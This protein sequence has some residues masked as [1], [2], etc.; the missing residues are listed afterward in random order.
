MSKIDLDTYVSGIQEI[1]NTYGNQVLNDCRLFTSL[2]ND[3][4]SLSTKGRDL[5]K[6]TLKPNVLNQI[7]SVNKC[8]FLKR[9]A[10][11]IKLESLVE[12]E[13]LINKDIVF[14]VVSVYAKVFSWKYVSNI[15]SSSILSNVS[16]NSNLNNSLKQPKNPS[17][18]RPNNFKKTFILT[19]LDLFEY[20]GTSYL[21]KKISGPIFLKNEA[22]YIGVMLMFDRPLKDEDIEV[23]WQIFNDNGTPFTKE[24]V[25][26]GKIVPNNTGYNVSWGW[27]TPGNWPIGKYRVV[28]SANG[29]KELTSSFEVIN[30]YYSQPKINLNNL[31]LFN[32]GDVAPDEN[33][34]QYSTSFQRGKLQRIYFELHFKQISKN[35]YTTINYKITYANGDVFANYAIP[36]QMQSGW[37]KCW[38]GIGWSEAGYWQEGLYRYEVSVGKSNKLCGSFVVR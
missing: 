14:E 30:G 13:C 21:S 24:M 7:Y 3:V 31:R 10:E 29:S 1:V 32:G 37:D 12:K 28:A 35:H 6:K 11:I 36:T 27:P 34:R 15:D 16:N 8:L 5:F 26:N 38:T 23:K 4:I 19:G 25:V 2:L 22:R 33:L 17:N 20:D 18:L 9:K